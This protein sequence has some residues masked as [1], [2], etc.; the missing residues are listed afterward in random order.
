MIG[1]D[2]VDDGDN[3]L[4]KVTNK[5]GT[6][7]DVQL[8]SDQVM[9]LGQSAQLFQARILAKRSRK[10]AGVEAV[11]STPVQEAI[12]NTDLLNEK[13]LLTLV[14]PNNARVVYELTPH[15]A[16]NLVQRLPARILEILAQQPSKQ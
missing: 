4:L 8:S 2:L 6:I 5:D 14:A 1:L 11:F 12:L 3:F 16:N 13:I 7:T 10:E 9:T 15:L